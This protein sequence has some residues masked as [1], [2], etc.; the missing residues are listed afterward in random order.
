LSRGRI[1]KAN[2]ENIKGLKF[3]T[4]KSQKSLQSEKIKNIEPV[5]KSAR[6]KMTKKNVQ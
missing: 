3:E 2:V 5:L 1:K 6:V 4:F